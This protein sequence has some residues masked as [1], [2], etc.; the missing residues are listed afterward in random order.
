MS[1]Y[2][3]IHAK[4]DSTFVIITLENLYGL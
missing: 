1:L 2:T 4:R 3:V